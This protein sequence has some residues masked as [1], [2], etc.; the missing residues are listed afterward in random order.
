MTN[1]SL[2]EWFTEPY[3]RGSLSEKRKFTK[4]EISTTCNLV[5]RVYLN[6]T[7]PTPPP[8][9]GSAHLWHL[10]SIRHQSDELLNFTTKPYFEIV[11]L[12]SFARV[13]SQG[14]RVK[15]NTHAQRV[16]MQRILFTNQ[17]W[18]WNLPVLCNRA[19]WPL[20]QLKF[21]QSRCHITVWNN[22]IVTLSSLHYFFEK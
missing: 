12:C 5:T 20:I 7:P 2:K 8:P 3:P 22:T 19:K 15:R 14:S 10:K 4:W 16:Q 13:D 11:K 6:A 1:H 18:W 9:H 21:H 17:A